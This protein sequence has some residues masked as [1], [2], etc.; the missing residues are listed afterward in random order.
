MSKKEKP[1][2]AATSTR[3]Y[4]YQQS[5]DTPPADHFQC[6]RCKLSGNADLFE[7]GWPERLHELI[8]RYPGMGI[9][10]DLSSMS[11]QDA[12]YLFNWL[13]RKR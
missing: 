5:N 3:A 11:Y 12:R 10:G 7:L 9:R 13:S 1:V 8:A 2:L 6:P 4:E